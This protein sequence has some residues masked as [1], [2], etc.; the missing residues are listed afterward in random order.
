MFTASYTHPEHGTIDVRR[1][2]AAPRKRAMLA[3]HLRVNEAY[4]TIQNHLGEDVILAG[5]GQVPKGVSAPVEAI[6]DW[7]AFAQAFE[8][9]VQTHNA[10]GLVLLLERVVPRAQFVPPSVTAK[11]LDPAFHYRA[12]IANHY[13]DRDMS[14]FTAL[15]LF[16]KVRGERYKP[17]TVSE[18]QCPTARHL[19]GAWWAFSDMDE[20]VL[21][22]LTCGL[23]SQVIDLR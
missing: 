12:T 4:I 18:S 7:T 22:K 16:Q 17:V 11:L 2:R 10:L 9:A 19:T 23:P 21:A 20:A 15:V 5:L 3:D 1:H 6:A 14:G 13:F 8:Q